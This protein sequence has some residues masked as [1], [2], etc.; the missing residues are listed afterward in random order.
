M[1]LFQQSISA[2]MIADVI[3]VAFSWSSSD[4]TLSVDWITDAY[5]AD[6]TGKVIAVLDG[7]TIEVLH[8]HD[9]FAFSI[10]TLAHFV[11]AR[12]L[13]AAAVIVGHAKVVGGARL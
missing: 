8:N 3:A 12:T 2:L 9:A 5:A 10:D 1:K 6:I 7:D 11:R 4:T 13:I